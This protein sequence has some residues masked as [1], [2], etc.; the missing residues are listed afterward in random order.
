MGND[1]RLRRLV[2]DE[3]TVYLWSFRHRHDSSQARPTDCRHVLSLTREDGR[4]RT[5]IVFRPGPGRAV[6]DGYWEAGTVVDMTAQDGDRIWLNL[7]EPGVVRR[8]VDEA[9]ARGLL[10]PETGP[11]ELDGWVL[12]HPAA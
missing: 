12:L 8:L 2:L 7:Y 10:P 11:R 4:T 1:R 6:S 3:R 5:A 9:T